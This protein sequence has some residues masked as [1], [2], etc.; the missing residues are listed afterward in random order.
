MIKYIAKRLMLMVPTLIGITFITYALVRI[1]SDNYVRN[2]A[3]TMSEQSASSRNSQVYKDEMKLFGLDKPVPEG[4]Y[5]WIKKAAVLDF[6]NSRKDGRK[7]TERILEVLPNSLMLNI[8]SIML[9]YVFSV[10]FGLYLAVKNG[11]LTDKISSFVFF[12]IY[13]IPSFWLAITMLTF[14]AGGEYFNLFPLEGI[15][16][17]GYESRSFIEKFFNI[18]WH[19][20]LPAVS[21]SLGEIVFL[22]LFVKSN[23]LDVL[24]RQF[25]ISARAKGLSEKRVIFIHAFR[26]SMIPLVTMIGMLIPSLFGGSVIV[27]SVYSIPGLG[28]MTFE[29][30]LSRDLPVIMSITLISAVLTLVGILV[31]DILYSVVNPKIRVQE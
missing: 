29:A 4:Y 2:M 8:Y 23:T 1:S 28:M 18:A 11:S 13:S 16:T 22:T 27:E 3:E 5:N 17:Y 19:L 24:G 15:I 6:G 20:T 21:L 7:V 10:S 14:F 9:I 31:S 12:V 25:I 30:F 26:N